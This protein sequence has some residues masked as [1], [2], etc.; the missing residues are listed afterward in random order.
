MPSFGGPSSAPL[1]DYTVPLSL[2]MA[3]FTPSPPANY[4]NFLQPLPGIASGPMGFQSGL[5]GAPM[6]G[7]P[8]PPAG[9]VLGPFSTGAPPPGGL[10]VSLARDGTFFTTQPHMVPSPVQLYRAYSSPSQ[11]MRSQLRPMMMPAGPP[12]GLMMGM[13][14]MAQQSPSLSSVSSDSL[15]EE[16]L[17]YLHYLSSPM[18]NNSMPA[19]YMA[20]PTLV[21]IPPIMMGASPLYASPY[22]PFPSLNPQESPFVYPFSENS[23]FKPGSGHQQGRPPFSKSSTS[24]STSTS[25]HA[26]GSSNENMTAV[27]PSSESDALAAPAS[28]KPKPHRSASRK[29]HQMLATSENSS[30]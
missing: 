29:I 20:S 7:P 5:P 18:G 1:T 27:Q 21:P 25:G 8:P 9:S 17:S 22:S 19:A 28:V 3:A 2:P 16:Q 14:L 13:P 11:T 23:R 6:P 4:N 30:A 15:K 10:P 12:G 26:H 24:P